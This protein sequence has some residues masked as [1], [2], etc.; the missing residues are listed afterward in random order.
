ME[1]LEG[2]PPAGPGSLSRIMLT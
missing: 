1:F 2:L